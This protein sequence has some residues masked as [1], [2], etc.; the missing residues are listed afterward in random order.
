MSAL[1]ALALAAGCG[2]EAGGGDGVRVVATTT[3][4]GDWARAVGG[5][6][7]SVHTILR[8]ETDPHDYEPRPSD[9]RAL[10]EA[11]VVLRSGGE[12]DEWLADLVDE[13]GGEAR[14]VDV[15][16]EIGAQGEDPHWWQDPRN[17]EEAV[18]AVRDALTEADAGGRAAFAT[19]AARYTTRLRALDRAIARCYDRVA[20]GKRTL[21]TSHDAFGWFARRYD[22]NV[23]GSIVPSRS[24]A[25]QPSAGD[26]ERLVRRI[27]DAGVTTIFPEAALD[28]RLEEAVARDAG[29][30]VGPALYADALGP[31]GSAGETYLGALAHDAAAIAAGFGARCEL[32]R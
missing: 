19:A 31:A 10:A 22:V 16:E 29:A 12:V 26:V 8:A 30:E 15:A 2:S 27:R 13:A 32:P 3:Q 9:A 21:V 1:S 6:R 11:D 23:L 7:A 5:P 24:T 25:A 17:A 20:P 14:V 28:Q 4:L 18:A